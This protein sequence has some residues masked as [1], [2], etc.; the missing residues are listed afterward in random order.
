VHLVL[1]SGSPRRREL[2]ALLGWDFRVV[3]PDVDES[4]RPSEDPISYVRRI[5]HTKAA[6]VEVDAG[7]VVVAADT[8]VELDG[9][10]LGKPADADDAVAMLR[11]LSGRTHR[12]HTAV[13]V[14]HAGDVRDDVVTTHVTFVVVPEPTLAWYVS[15][16]EPMDKAG[17]YALQGAGGVLVERID[18][19]ASNVVGL[20]LAQ[21]TALL[22]P[23]LELNENHGA[24]SDHSR[25]EP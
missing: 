25:K 14:R 6:A 17:A 15:T 19:S 11:A 1:A 16:G 9:R 23:L 8:T 20:P 7:A 22:R 10:I 4:S 21:L 13:V 24:G 12:V 18:G 3:V 5:A 2:L